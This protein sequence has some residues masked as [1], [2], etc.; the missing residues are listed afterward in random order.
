MRLNNVARVIALGLAVHLGLGTAAST[1]IGTVETKG[2]FRLDNATVAGNATLL[3]GATLE[4]GQALSTVELRSGARL[5]LASSSRGQFYGD[6]FVLEKGE[7]HIDR[8][9]TRLNSSH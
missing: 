4:A 3:E 2:S 6:R 5:L 1:V 8:K 7:S 9:S